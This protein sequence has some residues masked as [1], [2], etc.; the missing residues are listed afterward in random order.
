MKRRQGYG[1]G[2]PVAHKPALV[3]QAS[4]HP[5]LSWLN[6]LA[7]SKAPRCRKGRVYKPR[8]MKGS[9][10]GNKPAQRKRLKQPD[11]V[12]AETASPPKAVSVPNP[13]N[14]CEEEGGEG[15]AEP[16]SPA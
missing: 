15:A 8:C 14:I 16:A 2:P 10:R 3:K 5:T 9:P 1:A 6:K 12:N 7:R 13:R 4:T 11:L